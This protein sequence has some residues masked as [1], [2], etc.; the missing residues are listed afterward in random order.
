MSVFDFELL[1]TILGNIRSKV[2]DIEISL[3]RETPIIT[4]KLSV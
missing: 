3:T 1:L 4:G 2:R